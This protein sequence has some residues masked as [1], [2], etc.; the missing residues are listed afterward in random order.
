M[1]SLP[2]FAIEVE[3]A[4]INIEE[5]PMRLLIRRALILD[6]H[7]R[8]HLK[9]MDILVKKGVI[10][11]TDGKVD[12]K[13]ADKQIKESKDPARTPFRKE[14]KGEEDLT[15]AE[16]RRK[17][18]IYRA[19]LERL[20]YERQSGQLVHITT[21]TNILEKCIMAS[22]AKMLALPI[23]LAPQVVIC[24]T[25]PE[26]KEV[27][28][29]GIYECLREL[30]TIDPGDKG[31]SGTMGPAAKTHCKRVGRSKQKV[32]LGGKRGTRSVVNRKS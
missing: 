10:T 24:K 22:R 12:Y 32:K 1:V 8:H 19:E 27:I 9:R 3:K 29:G 23:K 18:E 20:E 13:Q 7:S 21:S 17:R 25:I 31:N 30:S 16:A 14:S 28:E 2:I 4:I 5:H 11:L 15:Y 6:P 26:V